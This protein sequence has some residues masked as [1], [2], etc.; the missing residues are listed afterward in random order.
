VAAGAD[1]IMIHSRKRQPDE[2]YEF[3]R[4]FR[5]EFS[6]TPLISVPTSYNAVTEAELAERGFNIV[7]YANQLLRAAYPAM[8]RVTQSILQHG[9]SLEADRELIS[10]NDILALIPGTK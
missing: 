2:I 6:N 3:A 9:R 10:I 4:Q 7:I 1:G 5:Q 8:Q